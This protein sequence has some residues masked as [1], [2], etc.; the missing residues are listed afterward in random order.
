MNLY[1]KRIMP[2]M[3]LVLTALAFMDKSFWQLGLFFSTFLILL[4]LDQVK[5]FKL[6]KD[7]L[8]LQRI[9]EEARQTIDELKKLALSIY[10]PVLK[11]AARLGRLD[12]HYG[13]LELFELSNEVHIVLKGLG[14][15]ESVIE[16]LTWLINNFILRD[17]LGDIIREKIRNENNQLSSLIGKKY[18]QNCK[19]KSFNPDINAIEKEINE[20]GLLNDEIKQILEEA[21]YFQKNKDIKTPSLFEGK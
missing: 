1:S 12:C 4:N 17:M 8:E 5:V 15:K 6:G 3:A 2:V 7:G 10:N 19:E 18:L 11:S 9:T 16:E 13:I 14:I 20:A 21:R